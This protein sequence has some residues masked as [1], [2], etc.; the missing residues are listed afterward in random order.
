MRGENGGAGFHPTFHRAEDERGA[1]MQPR[2]AFPGLQ[3]PT[4]AFLLCGGMKAFACEQ[5][6]LG[7][8]WEPCGDSRCP[9]VCVRPALCSNI[10]SFDTRNTLRPS[11][12]YWIRC[13]GLCNDG[14][15]ALLQAAAGL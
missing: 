3:A 2:C 6:L 5:S 10:A 12:R 15:S 8:P 1:E 7:A 13:L 14:L 11:T 4:T 9:R